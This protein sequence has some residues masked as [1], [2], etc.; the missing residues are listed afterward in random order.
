L[1]RASV[2]SE[3]AS[4]PIAVRP[5]ALVEAA[6]GVRAAARVADESAAQLERALAMAAVFGSA[7]VAFAGMSRSWLA[8]L[9][10]LVRA[11]GELSTSVEA[12]AAD[13]VRADVR[14]AGGVP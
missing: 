11:A 8:E 5:P 13:Y 3:L 1:T 14:A 12:A 7:Q 9:R 2:P 10:V 4:G 6:Q